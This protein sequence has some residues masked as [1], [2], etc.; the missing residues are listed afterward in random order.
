MD[1]LTAVKRSMLRRRRSWRMR[2]NR[3]RAAQPSHVSSRRRP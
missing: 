1:L 3:P 2:R